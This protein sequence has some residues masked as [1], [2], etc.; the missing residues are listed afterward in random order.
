MASLPYKQ[1]P[2]PRF[3]SF[4]TTMC[5]GTVTSLSFTVLPNQVSDTPMTMHSNVRP[6]TVPVLSLG[7]EIVY[8]DDIYDRCYKIKIKI[9]L[10]IPIPKPGKKQGPPQNLQPIILL[11]IIRNI[12]ASEKL[13][14]KISTTQAAYRAGRGTTEHAFTPKTLAEKPSPH[15]NMSLISYEVNIQ[16]DM[17]KA[18]VTI[19]RYV[20]LKDLSK[21]RDA[22]EL[23]I[24]SLPSAER[25]QF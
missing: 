15:L 11:S 20:L 9:G 25:H 22:D 16:Q 7:A 13:N 24:R 3:L 6:I 18:F 1:V 10:L 5:P 12:L 19:R 4:L 23:S 14:K 17:N 2:S 8:L 21:V